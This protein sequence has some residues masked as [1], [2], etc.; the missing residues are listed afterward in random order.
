MS[1]QTVESVLTRAMSDASFAEAVF[2]DAEKALA[3][4]T[5]SAEELAKFKALTR[6]QFDGMSAEDRKSFVIPGPILQHNESI[7]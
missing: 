5:L 3:E 2:A 7:L 4:Y 1:Q 6:A